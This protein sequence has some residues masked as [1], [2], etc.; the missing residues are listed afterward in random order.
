MNSHLV[1]VEVRV[2]GGAAQRVKLERFAL[3]QHGLKRLDAQTVQGRRAVE[4][5]G[6]LFND[7]FQYVPDLGL[8]ALD[9]AL[10]VLDVLRKVFADQPLHDEG[11]EQLQRHLLG[12]A[13]LIHFAA[14]RIVDTLAQQVLAETSLLAP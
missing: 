5:D 4:H 11:L 2:E 7:L 6:M 8:L 12:Q 13:A 1:A 9:G 3:D 10:C 14:A